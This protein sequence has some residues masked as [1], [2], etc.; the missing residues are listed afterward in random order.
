[1]RGVHLEDVIGRRDDELIFMGDE[2]RRQAVDQLG[3]V[4]HRHLVCMAI[5]DVERQPGQHRV[6]HGRGLAELMR[7][8]GFAARP[9]PRA[10]FVYDQLDAMRLVN[11]AHRRPM[12]VD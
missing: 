10:P 7:R 5:E 8:V 12:V 4:G 3:D 9:V 1:M 11:L 2:E 6:A